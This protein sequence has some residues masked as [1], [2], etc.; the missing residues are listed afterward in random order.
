MYLDPSLSLDELLITT[1]P[2]NGSTA[3]TGFADPQAV[4]E[5]C[6]SFAIMAVSE[7][8]TAF[9]NL[10]SQKGR[11][12]CIYAFLTSQCEIIAEEWSNTIDEI[13][14]AI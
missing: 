12:A 13:D 3:A 10:A 5:S 7:Y 11:E 9:N 8:T 14:T 6:D 2:E 4:V 1:C